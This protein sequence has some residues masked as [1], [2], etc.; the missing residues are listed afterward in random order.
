M[1]LAVLA[2]AATAA[3]DAEN[4]E[5]PHIAAKSPPSARRSSG[6]AAI[7]PRPKHSSRPDKGNTTYLAPVSRAKVTETRFPAT[8]A[9]RSSTHSSVNVK[10]RVRPKTF[11]KIAGKK[12]NLQR[13]TRSGDGYVITGR[14][15][16]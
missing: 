3:L 15:G 6:T 10:A 4:M 1:I 5:I 7:S 11:Y 8:P 13:I 2:D 12:Y 16:R 14:H 9:V